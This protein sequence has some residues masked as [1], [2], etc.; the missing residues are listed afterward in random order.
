MLYCPVLD[1]AEYN[2]LHSG[3][4]LRPCFS[5]SNKLLLFVAHESKHSDWFFT[6]VGP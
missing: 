6:Q 4:S 5:Q 1:L 3:S 2:S